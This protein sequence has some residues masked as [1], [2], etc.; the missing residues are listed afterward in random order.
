MHYGATS[1]FVTDNAELILMREAMDLLLNKLAKVIWNLSAFAVKWKGEPIF[2]LLP[3]KSFSPSFLCV[4]YPKENTSSKPKQVKKCPVEPNVIKDLPDGSCVGPK[5]KIYKLHKHRI[6]TNMIDILAIRINIICK[7][8][9]A[10]CHNN[11]QICRLSPYYHHH[12]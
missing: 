10:R 1:C 7:L 4:S 11:C 12:I 6:S 3:Y 2:V 9:I 5:W 8:S